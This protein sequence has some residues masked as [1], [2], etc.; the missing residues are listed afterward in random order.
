MFRPSFAS[1]RHWTM[2][3]KESSHHTRRYS[4]EE[5]PRRPPACLSKGHRLPCS[6]GAI[7]ATAGAIFHSASRFCV[8]KSLEFVF[9]IVA[10]S[11]GGPARL[12][13]VTRPAVPYKRSREKAHGTI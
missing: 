8:A 2:V 7:V 3:R 11:L 5:S 10:R 6:C 13:L 1:N 9:N 4:L 12:A